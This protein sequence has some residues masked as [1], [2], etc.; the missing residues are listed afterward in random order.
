MERK[1]GILLAWLLAMQ[2][3]HA[4]TVVPPASTDPGRLRDRIETPARPPAETRLPE[5]KGVG[6]EPVPEVLRALRIILST[7]RVEGSTVY[8]TAQLQTL[9]SPYL[10]REISGAEIFALAQALTARYRNDG[11]FLSVVVVPPQSLGS[12][13]LTL[14]AIEGHVAQVRVEG[15]PRLR[16]R[17]EEIGALIQAARP[18]SAQALERYLLIA[19]DFPGLRL[20]SVLAPSQTVGAAD[21]TLIASV[22]DVEG[23]YTY[24]NYGSRYLGPNQSTLGLTVNQLLGVNDQWRLVGAGTGNSEMAYAQLSYAQTVNAEGLQ[25]TAAVSQAR[26]RPGHTLRS[27][28]VRGYS[29]AWTLGLAYPWVRTRN[30]S[31][32]A[33]V[34]YDHA[35]IRSDILGA[36]VSEDHVRAL[37]AGLGWRVYDV[38]GGQN[39]LDFD[40]SKGLGGTREDDPLKSR[41]GAEGQFSKIVL[42]YTRN[43]PLG[44]PWSLSLG[45]AGQWTPRRPLLSS[46]QFALGGRRYGRAYEA[47]ELVGDRGWALRLEPR[48]HATADGYWLR[49]GQLFAF[50][51]IGEVQRYGV[52]SAGTPS[53]QSLASGGLG[54]RLF[55]AGSATA[56]LE[57]A[58]PLTKSI[59]SRPDEGQS[60]RLLASLLIPF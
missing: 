31:V 58:W 3:V 11:Y 7:I 56:Q 57:A 52:Q 49:G 54:T 21:L 59:A 26:T 30:R 9:T 23:F 27:F 53:H 39:T 29:D 60:A 1:L 5:I 50:Y 8:S 4:Q 20:R 19:N 2:A 40:Y 22:R 13:A 44:G 15:D 6:Q 10:G 34:A 24:D 43:Q 45:L 32:S 37:R 46:E 33:R 12:G 38:L 25:L 41:V 14:R 36:R 42:D 48:R 17:L 51:D 16:G 18:L 55:L 28:D 47:A 35:D